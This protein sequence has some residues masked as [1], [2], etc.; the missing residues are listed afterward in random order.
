MRFFDTKIRMTTEGKFRVI[1]F[2]LLAMNF[3]TSHFAVAQQL[4][5]KQTIAI[6]GDYGV[7]NSNEAAVAA[8]VK[9]WKPDA[10]FTTGDNN[11]ETGSARSIDQNIGKYYAEFIYPYRGKYSV[12]NPV[13][14]NRFFPSLGNHDWDISAKP[15]YNYFQLPGNERYYDIHFGE[16]HFFVIN[17]N[18]GEVDGISQSSR[19]ALW[20]Q[21]GL[22]KSQARYK[23]V[24]FHHPPYTSESDHGPEAK[25]Q[26]PFQ[27]WGA[28]AVFTG[29]NHF[30]ER[31]S[32]NGFPY[33]VNGAG[34]QDLYP[35]HQISS[36]SLVR[37]ENQFGAQ[38]LELDCGS[39]VVRFFTTSGVSR[40]VLAF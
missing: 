27:A 20:L 25:L 37:V 38:K 16:A 10:V 14:V 18:S 21:Q 30:Y 8:L 22:A 9:S 36:A 7:N 29:H 12:K 32:V 11:Y 33:F 28:T 23:F 26:W 24:V 31:L 39:A 40:D 5:C 15:Y 19:Q 4:G 3:V 34:G 35:I 13:K 1:V 6:I 17:S 2:S